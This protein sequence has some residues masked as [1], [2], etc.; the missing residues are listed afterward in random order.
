VK[1]EGKVGTMN[2]ILESMKVKCM[3]CSRGRFPGRR[4]A[5]CGNS[6]IDRRYYFK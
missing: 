4:E 2:N 3:R 1:Q 5:Q 6:N